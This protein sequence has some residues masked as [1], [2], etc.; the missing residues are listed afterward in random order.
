M[1]KL[2]LVVSI[3]SVFI[4][5]AAVSCK[6]KEKAE[7]A[8]ASGLKI[9]IVTSSGVDDGSFGQDCYIGIQAF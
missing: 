6:P 2:K 8:K 9:S 4:L 1:K 3:F 7:A 5:L